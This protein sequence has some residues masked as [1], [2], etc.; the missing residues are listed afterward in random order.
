M[1]DERLPALI[2][3]VPPDQ[4]YFSLEFFPPKTQA[5][6][7]NLQSRLS[8]MATA[9]KPLYVTVTW[10][11]GGSTSA[12]SLELAE[13]TQRQLG[14]PTVLHLTCTNMRRSMVDEALE[15]CKELGI[16]NILALRGDPPR[17]EYREESPPRNGSSSPK[18]D[19]FV[20]AIDLVKY[21][22]KKHGDYFALGV[23]GYPEGH[24]DES[25]PEAGKQSVEHDLPYLV[26]KLREKTAHI[27]DRRRQRS[28]YSDTDHPRLMPIQSY[29][30]VKRITKLSHATLPKDIADRIEKVKDDDNAVKRV[31]VDIM[32]E[33]VEQIR[34]LPQPEGLPRGLH[35]YTLNLEKS[36]AFI[37]E[38]CHLLPHLNEASPDEGSDSD[39][40]QDNDYVLVSNDVAPPSQPRISRRRASSVNAQPTTVLSWTAALLEAENRTGIP[41]ADPN[42]KHSLLISEGQGSLGREATWDDFPNGRWGPA[43]SPAYGEIDGY[44]PS[45]KVGPATARKLWGS[46]TSPEDVTS[47]FSRLITGDLASIPWSDEVDPTAGLHGPGSLRAETS[48][49]RE[50]ILDLIQRKH[51]WTLAS[52]PAVD[53]ARSN[54]EVFGWGPRDEGFV[55]QKAFVEFFCSRSEWENVLRKK[56][57]ETPQDHLSWMKTDAEGVYESSDNITNGASK[58][59]R[60]SSKR[61]PGQSGVNAVTWG[62]FRG[63]EIVT[64]TIIESESFRAWGEEAFAIWAEWRRCYARGSSEEQ[65]LEALRKDLVLV[66]VVG[67]DYVGGHEGNGR[68]LWDVLRA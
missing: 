30:I 56:L 45:L 15:A 7:N 31:G 2:A 52:Q 64:P 53:G 28:I 9:L 43:H 68:E 14:L 67:Q 5:G 47:M 55:F 50:Q 10:G 25:H 21:I 63:K 4:A 49:I 8:R 65:T 32:S 41:A 62:V 20:W 22:R 39:V 27:Q 42:R 26:D 54:D 40:V 3:S 24:A 29:Q 60:S 46:P 18:P 35:F 61:V 37:L 59:G 66:N 34:A 12:K 33:L 48:V 1:I 36:V 11:A 38:R 51:Y 19:E 57:V 58:P 6:F 17:E 13:V 16:R 23:A 44:G